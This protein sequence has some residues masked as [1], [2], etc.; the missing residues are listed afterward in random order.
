[1]G[2]GGK[3]GEEKNII[4]F[5]EIICLSRVSQTHKILK[6]PG[7]YRSLATSYSLVGP[8]L[9]SRKGQQ[10]FSS[11]KHF[12]YQVWDPSSLLFSGY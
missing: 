2:G 3:N 5:S 10:I 7:Y 6:E 8:R 4:P 1:M 12:P 9:E 11:P